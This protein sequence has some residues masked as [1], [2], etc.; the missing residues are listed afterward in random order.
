MLLLVLIEVGLSVVPWVR[1][2]KYEMLV[3]WVANIPIVEGDFLVTFLVV[4]G[5][6]DMSAPN[7]LVTPLGVIGNLL[8][9]CFIKD[10]F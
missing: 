6:F 8:R 7:V 10:R 5:A 3:S 1:V 2:W 9:G 4:P